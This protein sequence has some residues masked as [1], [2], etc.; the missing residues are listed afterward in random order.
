MLYGKFKLKR[1]SYSGLLFFRIE[2]EDYVR[3]LHIEVED[4]IKEKEAK[5]DTV[6]TKQ[7]NDHSYSEMVSMYIQENTNF[8]LKFSFIKL[9]RLS[10]MNYKY[11][12]K[13][14]S[15]TNPN[16][17]LVRNKKIADRVS[18]IMNKSSK[19]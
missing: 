19:L 3:N 6:Q 1:Q 4:L 12:V 2:D 11:M 13:K 16:F 18:S 17:V 10:N 5:L 15:K 9:N 7:I 14:L 8:K